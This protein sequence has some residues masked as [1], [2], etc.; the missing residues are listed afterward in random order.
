MRFAVGD[1]KP[2]V[3]I[4]LL[5]Y[6]HERWIRT[7]IDS[8]LMQETDFACEFII[9]EDCSPDKTREI[10]L[11]Y[12]EKYPI[13]LIL[14]EKNKGAMSNLRDLMNA[15]I[16]KYVAYMEGDDSWIDPLKLKKQAALMESD[17][18]IGLCY[19]NA[20]TFDTQNPESV[21]F[22]EEGR[23]PPLRRDRYH[24]VVTCPAPS[25]TLFFKNLLKP[26][27][28]W[29]ETVKTGDHLIVA[30]ACKYGDAYYMDEPMG[31][32]NHDYT[33]LSRVIGQEHYLFDDFL[34]WF[35]LYEHYDRDP[36][37][38]DSIVQKGYCDIDKLFYRGWPSKARTLFWKW[39]FKRVLQVKRHRFSIM[40]MA[41]KIHFPYFI[42][43]RRFV[44]N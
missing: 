5:T 2:L 22:F 19:A 16:G 13:K 35:N 42:Q 8:I 17:D 30:L 20:K 14:Q 31:L 18:S 33:G 1:E 6:K 7:A 38:W 21:I 28:V 24:A 3:S 36:K 40:K 15:P 23:K 27:P 44:K 32:Y 29:A 26:Y 34:P 9:A 37:I 11:S 4:C 12:A 43:L 41:I 10:V 39:P 25:C